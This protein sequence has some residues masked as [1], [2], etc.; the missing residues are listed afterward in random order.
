MVESSKSRHR[1]GLHESSKLRFC[2]HET[3]TL[4]IGLIYV[5]M[6]KV[7]RYSQKNRKGI[8]LPGLHEYQTGRNRYNTGKR[9]RNDRNSSS[10]YDSKPFTET[11]CLIF[12][13]LLAPFNMHQRINSIKVNLFRIVS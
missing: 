4:E 10:F 13:R 5:K 1:F 12:F 9:E 7:D 8:L 3:T 11:S 6:K 2:L